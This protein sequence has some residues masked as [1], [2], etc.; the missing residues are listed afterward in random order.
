M[1]FL[2]FSSIFQAVRAVEKRK[3]CLGSC[4]SPSLQVC[5]Q[6]L[7]AATPQEHYR[8]GDSR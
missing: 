6:S 4:G 5:K 7:A 2:E 3:D 8:L 1:A